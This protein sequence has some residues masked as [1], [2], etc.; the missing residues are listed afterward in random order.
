MR[1]L[2]T[3]TPESPKEVK[4]AKK[5]STQTIICKTSQLRSSFCS[6]LCRA[7]VLI[8]DDVAFNLIPL[9]EMLM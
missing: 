9:E 4:K 6:D 8:V 1:S 7:T 5:I 2:P 3:P